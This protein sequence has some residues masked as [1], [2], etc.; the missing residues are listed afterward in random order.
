[1]VDLALKTLLHDK[2]RFAITVAGVA[3]AVMLVLIQGGLFVGILSNSYITIDKLNADL[4]VTSKNT[5]NVDFAHY[6]PENRLERVR[7]TPGV[8]RADN[9]LVGFVGIALP[10]GAAETLMIYGLEDFA[11]WK[12]PWHIDAGNTEDLKRG[13]YMLLDQSARKRFGAFQVGDYREVSGRRMKIIGSTQE[14]RSFT[15]TPIAFMDYHQAQSLNPNYDQKTAYMLVK[16]APGA[17]RESVRRELQTRLP[18]NDVFTKEEWATRSRDYW[19][20]STGIG[21]NMYLTVFLGC[22]V[23]LVIV[24]QTLYSSTMEHIREFGTVKAIGGSNWDIYLIIGRQAA[25]AAIVGYL[26]GLVPAFA[27]RP[28][29]TKVDLKLIISPSFLVTSFVV[30][31]AMCLGAAAISFRKVSAIDPG[32]VF[33]G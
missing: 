27:I 29:L 14:A 17:D 2:L 23:G 13:P 32:L 25:I 33:R 15:T 26:V 3:F 6:Y 8:A 21:F 12:F 20:K 19:I 11:A 10:T 30:T 1:M 9:L 7:S 24:A 28:W 31:L 18:Y 22:L 16:L 5:P 4:W